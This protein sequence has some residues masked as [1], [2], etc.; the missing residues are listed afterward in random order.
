LPA[1][2]SLFAG[3]N[4]VVMLTAPHL[5]SHTLHVHGEAPINATSNFILDVTYHLVITP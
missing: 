5:G 3:D 4:Y 1:G 2:P